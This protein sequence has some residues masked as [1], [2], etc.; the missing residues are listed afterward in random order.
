MRYVDFYFIL[1]M[2][3]YSYGQFQPQRNFLIQENVNTDRMIPKQDRKM[4]KNISLRLTWSNVN[5]Y[6]PKETEQGCKF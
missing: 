4:E 1:L 2:Q 3:L 6:V 5:F